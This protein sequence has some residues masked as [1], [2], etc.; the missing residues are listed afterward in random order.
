MSVF[1]LHIAGSTIKQYTQH[2]FIRY[3]LS[4]IGCTFFGAH[5]CLLP[6]HMCSKIPM[7]HLAIPKIHYYWKPLWSYLQT[8]GDFQRTIHIR[9]PKLSLKITHYYV[10]KS[11]WCNSEPKAW[12]RHHSRTNKI[13]FDQMTVE[14]IAQNATSFLSLTIHLFQSSCVGCIGYNGPNGVTSNER[15]VTWTTNAKIPIESKN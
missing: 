7:K 5:R 4:W 3:V 13:A 14:N 8:V 9:I 6:R 15:T 11:N 12:K 2:S 1:S 10:I